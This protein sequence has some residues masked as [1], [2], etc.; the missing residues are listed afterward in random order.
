MTLHPTLAAFD[1]RVR[2]A[3]EPGLVRL[4]IARLRADAHAAAM[5]ML[6][7]LRQRSEA[8]R[9]AALI[10]RAAPPPAMAAAPVA[11][12]R[13]PMLLVPIMEVAQP[14]AVPHRAGAFWLGMDPLSVMCAQALRRHAGDGP[15][16]A[17]FSP[18]QIAM[19]RR[20]MALV[21]RHAA[22]GLRCASVEARKDGSGGGAGE[23]GF[24][25]ALLD[26]AAEIARIR[27]RIGPGAA[28]S[29]R[30]TRPSQR[31]QRVSIPDLVLV[32]MVLLQGEPLSAVLKR[33]GWQTKDAKAIA[34]LRAALASA[35]DR[36]QGYPK[37]RLDA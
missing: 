30:R 23:G 20:Y 32:D 15:F 26:E 3:A 2:A 21:E 8:A 1:A 14:N 18:G 4:V 9:C 19:A 10:D 37:K 24:I 6:A 36:A 12:A 13:G 16:T 27:R 22:A 35:M 33:H 28:L 17:P 11:P 31:G 5:A 7:G 34:T 25:D 29:V